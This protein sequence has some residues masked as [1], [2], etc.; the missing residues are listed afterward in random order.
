MRSVRS[1]WAR[2]TLHGSHWEA[3][4]LR[5]VDELFYDDVISDA[6]WTT[7]AAGFEEAQM[8]DVLLTAASYR[9][10][11]IALNS[12]GVQPDRGFGRLPN[13]AR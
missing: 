8:I 13:I 9:M 1:R 7:L 3:A 11:A 6:T 10:T 2:P 5:A 12:L 4:L